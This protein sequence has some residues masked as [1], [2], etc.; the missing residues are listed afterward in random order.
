MRRVVWRARALRVVLLALAV[1]ITA[2]APTAE[3]A[4][5]CAVTAFAAFQLRGDIWQNF[6]APDFNTSYQIAG[7]AVSR[8]IASLTRHVDL[9]GEG[10]VIKH[11]GGQHHEEFNALINARWLTFPWNDHL[12]TTF[13]VGNGLSYATRTA[14]LEESMHGKTSLLLDCM[15]FE[16]TVALPDHPRWSLAWRV[17]HRSGVFGLFN[18]VEGA[19]NAMGLGLKYRF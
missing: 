2:A 10:Q 9:E 16:L 18:G 13:A 17:H 4:E 7:L 6:Y 5:D 15:M 19:S 11:M 14:A 12:R 1:A 3:A 8:K